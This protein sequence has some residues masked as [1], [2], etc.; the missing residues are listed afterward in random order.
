[1]V[2]TEFK[3]YTIVRGSFRIT[4]LKCLMHLD[5]LPWL[6]NILQLL[7]SKFL[8]ILLN[9]PPCLEKILELL[10]SNG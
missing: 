2:K 4:Y 6:E 1:M 8:K 7:I 5:H 9:Y 10:I 3:L